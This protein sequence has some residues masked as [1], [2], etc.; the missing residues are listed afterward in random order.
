MKIPLLVGALALVVA[1]AVVPTASAAQPCP[2]VYPYSELC[3]GD[4]GGFVRGVLCGHDYCFHVDCITVDPWYQLCQGNV[5]GF[6]GWWLKPLVD[7]VVIL[8]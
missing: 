6:V 5:G 2:D 8:P 4:V 7:D 3:Q 1:T